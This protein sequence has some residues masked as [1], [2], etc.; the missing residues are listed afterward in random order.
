[1]IPVTKLD[2]QQ[3]VIN[4]DLVEKIE[5]SPDT[6]IS[7]TSGR[8]MLVRESVSELMRLFS[9][10]RLNGNRPETKLYPANMLVGEAA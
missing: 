1:M 8:K 10:A 5:S 4:G 6:I 3:V 9:D 7:L 2:G